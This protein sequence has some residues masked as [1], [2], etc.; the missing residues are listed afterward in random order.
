ML[1]PICANGLFLSKPRQP[2]AQAPLHT[3]ASF[4][5]D[6]VPKSTGNTAPEFLYPLAPFGYPRALPSPPITFLLRLQGRLLSSPSRV[7]SP[8]PANSFL[9]RRDLSRRLPPLCLGLTSVPLLGLGPGRV[10]T[11]ASRCTK[12]PLTT[13]TGR[14]LLDFVS[15]FFKVPSCSDP[16]FPPFSYPSLAMLQAFCKNQRCKC[17]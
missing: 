11:V 14:V 6:S 10:F 12:Y 5:C 9:S 7:F 13:S 4:L 2:S 1:A 17:V 8:T 3:R 15:M 16:Q